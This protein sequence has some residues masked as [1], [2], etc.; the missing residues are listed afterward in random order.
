MKFFWFFILSAVFVLVLPGFAH[1]DATKVIFSELMWRGSEVSTS[2]EWIE[3]FNDSENI[4]DLSGWRIFDEIK[5]FDMLS[6]S[7]GSISPHGYFLIS[8]NSQDHEFSGGKSTLN[9]SPDLVDSSVSLNNSDFK[10]SLK[11]PVGETIDCAGDGGK[12]FYGEFDDKIASQQRVKPELSGD[13]QDAWRPSMERKNLDPGSISYATPGTWGKTSISL[14]LLNNLMEY[15][16]K[17]SLDFDWEFYDPASEIISVYVD[18]KNNG[19]VLASQKIEDKTFGFH[20]LKVCPKAEIRFIDL[21]GTFLSQE[22]DLV[23][24]QKSTDIKFYETL[25][26]PSNVDWNHDGELNLKDEWIELVNFS[27]NPVNL[28]GWKIGDISGR[29]F[30]IGDIS[31]AANL[32]REFYSS[33][34][35]LSLNDSKETLYLFDPLGKIV[36]KLQIPSSASKLDMSYSFW[37]GLWHWTTTPTPSAKNII[38]Q[39][40]SA[41]YKRGNAKLEG[42]IVTATGKIVNLDREGMCI[43]VDGLP[44][45]IK[46][47]EPSDQFSSGQTITVR[48][49]IT[50]LAIP[51]I[52]AAVSDIKIKKTPTKRNSPTGSLAKDTGGVIITTTRTTKKKHIFILASRSRLKTFILPDSQNQGVRS[53]NY[54][55]FLLYCAGILSILAVI[56]IYDFCCR[57]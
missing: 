46:L 27:D 15:G 57:K 25:P 16:K 24:Y 23:C 10:I 43:L 49:R 36:D 1:A 12:P 32:S 7:S 26:H 52:V 54:Q 4:I 53:I 34:S 35:K 41:S 47:T 55:R 31:I 33:Q 38:K 13:I 48:G 56:L 3:L 14:S 8:N 22:F 30:T 19:E 2:D 21:N 11:N 45:T 39:T 18:L 50:N 29:S 44:V 51:I 37:G 5:G 6:I 20:S 42:K 40:G 9:I 28:S 17:I